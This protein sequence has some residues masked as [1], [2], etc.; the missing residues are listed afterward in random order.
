MENKPV[1]F[2][3]TCNVC[4]STDVLCNVSKFSTDIL[5]FEEKVEFI[6]SPEIVIIE[7]RNCGNYIK[8]LI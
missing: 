2:T 1:A 5:S 3:I 6:G 7:C 8:E 4:G